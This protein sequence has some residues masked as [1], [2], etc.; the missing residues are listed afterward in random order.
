M[1]LSVLSSTA[2]AEHEQQYNTAIGLM[3][4]LQN[5][6]NLTQAQD[7]F[8][9]MGTYRNSKHFHRYLNAII[10]LY[11]DDLETAEIILN[12]LSGFPVFAAELESRYLPSCDALLEYSS[13]RKLEQA[14]DY[15]EAI[16]LYTTCDVLDSVDRV[17]ALAGVTTSTVQQQHTTIIQKILYIT[18]A[19]I[20][21][22]SACHGI[23]G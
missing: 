14:E 9:E 20:T 7:M 21:R 2:E 12:A 4:D 5:Q 6:D 22:K 3:Y 13:A 18:I 11:N 17:I 8:A 1:V 10:S 23:V 15:A 19:Y 16:Q